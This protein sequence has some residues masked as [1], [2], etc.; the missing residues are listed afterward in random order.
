MRSALPQAL[1]RIRHQASLGALYDAVYDERFCWALIEAASRQADDA[2]AGGRLRAW[3]TSLF[4]PLEQQAREIDGHRA[5]GSEGS[6]SAIILGDSLF[7]KIYRRDRT[8]VNPEV[9]MGRFLTERS[10]F[11]HIARLAGAIE[12]H[13]DDGHVASIAVLQEHVAAQGDAWSQVTNHLERFFE[14]CLVRPAEEQWSEVA[15]SHGLNLALMRQLGQRTGELHAALARHTE[16]PAFDPEP[17]TAEDLSAWQQVMQDEARAT[18]ELLKRHQARLG[19]AAR[20]AAERLLAMDEA[21]MQR[22]GAMATSGFEGLKTRFHGDFHLGQALVVEN[23]LVLIDFEGEPARS[24][25]ARRRKHTPLKDVAGML[26]SFSYAAHSAVRRVTADRA[27]GDTALLAVFAQ[28]W[29]ARATEAFLLG[30]EAAEGAESALYAAGLR[31]SSQMVALLAI[32]K[33]LYEV[34]Y[35]INNR[36]DWADIP[37]TGVLSLLTDPQSAHS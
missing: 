20:E 12:F 24:L 1:A 34:R 26:R 10:P 35:E 21:L 37:L 33:A 2:V 25:E 17:V 27:M 29:V 28:D 19:E 30:Y 31:G 3:K 18:F 36:P 7:L 4:D 23:D 16:D 8:G 14:D 5:P 15:T 9:E 13:G 22:I 32:E 11:A 6:N